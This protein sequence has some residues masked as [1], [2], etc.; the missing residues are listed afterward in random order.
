MRVSGTVLSTLALLL[1]FYQAPFSH[2]HADDFD[3]PASAAPVHW[4]FHR[5]APVP[6]TPLISASTADDDAIDVGWNALRCSFTGIPFVFNIAEAVQPPAP[7][8]VAIPVRILHR[9]GHDPPELARQSP[10]APPA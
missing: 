4:H 6:P 2:I 5:E 10:R 7:A 3:H 9:R 8:P 1:G